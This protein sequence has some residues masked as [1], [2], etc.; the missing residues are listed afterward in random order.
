M[1]LSL[2]A[3]QSAPAASVARMELASAALMPAAPGRIR[4]V[5]TLSD[6]ALG[7]T[8]WAGTAIRP[9]ASASAPP[10]DLPETA[11]QEALSAPERPATPVFRQVAVESQPTPTPVTKPPL[12]ARAVPDSAPPSVVSKPLVRGASVSAVVKSFA[13]FGYDL[14]QVRAAA[15]PVPRLYLEALPR[16]LG[17]LS[18]VNAR[19]RLFIQSVLPIILRV[20]EEIVTARWRVERLKDRLL[21]DDALSAADR[22]WLMDVAELYGAAPFDLPGLL[23]RMDIVPPSLALAQAAEETGWG[24]SRFVRE[25]NA[26]F[27][28]YT[29][30]SVTGMLPKRRDADSRHR[31][32]RHDSLLDAV[33]AYA[34]NLNSHW[35]YEDFRDRRAKLRRDGRPFDGYD[36]AGKLGQY[37]ERRAA[38]VKTIRTIMR[39]NR[40]GD[41]DRAWL[42]NRQWT[43]LIGPRSDRPI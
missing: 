27:G 22:E 15:K 14:D 11:W 2:V 19:K 33:R 39:Q 4:L 3:A 28:Q 9:L 6:T 23:M 29:Y 17:N 40:L 42:N 8:P 41:F 16:G 1:H 25:G 20:N 38:Y 10:G 5:F 26:L 35:A 7:D 43:A 30:K 12:L 34:H 31:V 24:T 21:R 36:L 32:R 13:S 37:S 18:S